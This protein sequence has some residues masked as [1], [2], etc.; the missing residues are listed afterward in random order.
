MGRNTTMI[1]EANR[2]KASFLP[3]QP[4]NGWIKVVTKTNTTAA[5]DGPTGLEG[6]H[7]SPSQ[8]QHRGGGGGGG[9]NCDTIKV[10]VIVPQVPCPR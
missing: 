5:L 6:E 10:K 7:L 1:S 3:C 4:H 9:G 2:L 8:Y